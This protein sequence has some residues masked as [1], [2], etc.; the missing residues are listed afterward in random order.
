MPSQPRERGSGA[1]T[2]LAPAGTATA[3][4]RP[5]AATIAA[6]RPFTV[7]LQ[8]GAWVRRTIRYASRGVSTAIRTWP[9]PES[10]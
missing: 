5:L 4:W 7:A 2:S 8:P 3:W 9:A 1:T 6:G 10:R